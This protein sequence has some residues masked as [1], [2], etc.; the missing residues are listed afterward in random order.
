[1]RDIEEARALLRDLGLPR[2]LYNDMACYTLI[3]MTDMADHDTWADTTNEFIG[4]HGVIDY[5]R[6]NDLRVYAE[7]SRESF[8][9]DVVKPW[10]NL[11][12]VEDNGE[13]TNSG[14]MKY[15]LKEE[16]IQLIRTY[17][18]EEWQTALHYFQIYHP[19][20]VRGQAAERTITNMNVRINGHDYRLSP[21]A[22]NI[23]QK[24]VAEVFKE[25]FARDSEFV[26]LGDSTDRQLYRNAEILEALGFDITLDVLPDIVLY[27]RER[28]WLFFI[29]CVTTVGP[30]SEQRKRD[31]ENM[32]RGVDAGNIYVTAFP[33]ISTFKKHA[34]NLAWE[35]E[36]WISDMP[37]HL[38]HLNGDHF[39]GPRR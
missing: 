25:H 16:V 14:N 12:L 32:T 23:L 4:M 35:T 11:A 13:P 30:V 28:N 3:A 29:E 36:V 27:D 20:L 1:M 15:R 8:R 31:I 6:E 5:L 9:K 34:E 37:T 10:R 17:G 18:T 19:A 26:Y 7:N 24:E 33:N 38:I 22:H 2:K 21:G 39:I